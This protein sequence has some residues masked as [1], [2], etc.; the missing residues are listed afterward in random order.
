MSIHKLEA[1]TFQI[2]SNEMDSYKSMDIHLPNGY[3]QS[4]MEYPVV[5]LFD[6]DQYG[7]FTKSIYDFYVWDS[8][9][10]FI[11]VSIN[12]D[13]RWKELK[14][15][16]KFESFVLKELMPYIKKNY[17]TTGFNIAVG[18]SFG[19]SFVL[20]LLTK[21]DKIKAA[22]S[23]SPVIATKNYNLLDVYSQYLSKKEFENKKIYLS[24]G[25][26]ESE[27]MSSTV[28]KFKELLDKSNDEGIRLSFEA[29][30][31]EVHETSVFLGIRRGLEDI[32][33]DFYVPDEVWEEM[34]KEK[35]PSK[36]YDYFS[37][38][39]QLYSAKIVPTED[40][41]N[42]LGYRLVDYKMMHKAIKVLKENIKRFPYSYNA[43]DSL[44][45]IYLK[46]GKKNLAIYYYGQAFAMIK[47]FHNGPNLEK[48]KT[49]I[50]KILSSKD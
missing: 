2:Y 13:N 24:Y 25:L 49:E 6:G 20:D 39:K 7:D 33:D 50:N 44:G 42:S 3:G 38:L 41:L 15:K 4:T 46:K 34:D 35:N 43:Y 31:N 23:I 37:H 32:F 28:S 30:P 29:F 18:H 8:Y 48:Y 26:E 16:S 11:I 14:P 19:G 45:E 1:Q 27:H 22:V 47:A 10:Q 40:D 36:F 12:Q 17:K 21:S 9:P 5:F